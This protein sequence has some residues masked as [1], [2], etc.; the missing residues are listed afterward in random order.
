MKLKK[1]IE[2]MEKQ[3]KEFAEKA[4]KGQFRKFSN[5][6]YVEH[7]K[8]VAEIVKKFKNSHKINDLISAAL[9]HDTVEDTGTTTKDLEKMFGGLVASL[10]KE[11]TSNKEDMEKVGGKR[12]YL[13]NKMVNMS[14]WALVIK[15]ADRLDNV[16]DLKNTSPEF[17]KKYKKETIYI[18]NQLEKN[19][20]LTF[21]QE[22]IVNEI[23]DKLRELP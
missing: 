17:I 14:S 8:R 5:E 20:K 15:L 7:P 18:L 22:K 9:L 1:I 13:A 16:S 19:R 21:T 11:L 3:A 10:V 4:H 12:V 6:E 23:K 2:N